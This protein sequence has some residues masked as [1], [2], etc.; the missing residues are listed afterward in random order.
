MA[1]VLPTTQD[2]I[3]QAVVDKLL[4]SMS[5]I[6]L[7]TSQC[8]IGVD[9]D[10]ENAPIQHNWFLVVS[11][12]AGQ[13]SGAMIDGGGEN[14]VQEDSGVT[15]TVYSSLKL[16]RSGQAEQV[17]NHSSR[18]LLY[19]K[20]RT[21]KA[22]AGL[23]LYSAAAPTVPLLV[24]H[25][26]PLGSGNPETYYRNGQDTAKLHRQQLSFSTDFLWDLS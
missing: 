1:D 19:L 2:I 6:G 18:G 12:M 11:P 23:Q 25:M 9:S 7:T 5:D 13:F 3:L 20:R 24:N 8:W 21:L 14:T 4:A 15:I 10:I 22:L 16:D 17:L 26:A